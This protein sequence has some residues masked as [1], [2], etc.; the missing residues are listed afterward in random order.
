MLYKYKTIITHE[1]IKSQKVAYN[2]LFPYSYTM[3]YL[4]CQSGLSS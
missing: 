2:S 1:I 4:V 3:L